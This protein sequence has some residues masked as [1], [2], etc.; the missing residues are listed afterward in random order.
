MRRVFV[1]TNYYL[2]LLSKRDN[3]HKA[4]LAEGGDPSIEFVTTE[5]VLT[6]LM[7][8]LSQGAAR[9]IAVGFIQEIRESDNVIIEFATHGLFQSGLD[10]YI[11]R[12]DKEWS[13][14]DCISFV[15]MEREGLADALTGDRHF[16]QAGFNA[17]LAG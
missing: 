11:A 8:A 5:W 1:D 9:K 3:L 12:P 7:D 15:V 13:L 4:A 2:A 16:V 10:L 6:E 17:L 14:T